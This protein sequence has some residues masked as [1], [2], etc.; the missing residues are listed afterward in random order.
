MRSCGNFSTSMTWWRPSLL[1]GLLLS[2][3]GCAS[4]PT[5][6]TRV[7]DAARTES[8]G[9]AVARERARRDL[10]EIATDETGFTITEQLRISA[11]ARADYQRALQSLGQ[12]RHEEG[13]ARL[14]AVIELAPEATAPHIDLGIAYG[15][16]GDLESAEAAL[17]DALALTP[18][19]PIALNELGIL[20]RKTGRFESARASYEKA[21]AIYPGFHYAR[22]NLAV[23]CDLYLADPVCALENYEAY[24]QAVNDDNEVA[25]WVAD[26]RARTTP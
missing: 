5:T 7:T 24:L 20:Y 18:N 16:A 15:R 22:R 13:I 23:L 17:N 12:G 10:P 2:I 25:I 26:L 21:L 1:V 19:H 14:R 8:S 4:Q 9:G 6:D 11:E 3:V